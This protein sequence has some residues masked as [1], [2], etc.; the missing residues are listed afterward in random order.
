MF[1]RICFLALFLGTFSS[2]SAQLILEINDVTEEF[3][4]TGSD[5]VI[6]SGNNISWAVSVPSVTV[7]ETA[8]YSTG[9]AYTLAFGTLN[10]PDTALIFNSNFNIFNLNL[11]FFGTNNT[12]TGTGIFQ[13]YSSLDSSN[14][15]ILASLD[16]E[17]FG[18]LFGVSDNPLTVSVV[19]EPSSAALV[20]LGLGAVG[21]RRFRK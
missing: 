16:G 6:T 2:A 20:L 11:S 8:D 10:T 19:P 4:L 21:F 7:G 14:K 1:S 3:A 9:D 15:A 12:V 13:S 18:T 17:S 5:F